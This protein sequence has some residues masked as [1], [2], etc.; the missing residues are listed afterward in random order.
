MSTATKVITLF[1]LVGIVFLSGCE[2]LSMSPDTW[3]DPNRWEEKK[4]ATYIK[5]LTDAARQ[6]TT[7][8][9]AIEKNNVL[10]TSSPVS[11]QDQ[12]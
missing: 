8:D 2:V 3:L 10:L 4:Q 11:R 9:K 7:K 6:K 12:D 5:M 1:F